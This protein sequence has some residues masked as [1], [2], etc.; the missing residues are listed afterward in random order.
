MDYT[1]ILTEIKQAIDTHDGEN[2]AQA[3]R[4]LKAAVAVMTA[5]LSDLR[6]V[7]TPKY[8]VPGGIP[9]VAPSGGQKE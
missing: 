6:G 5:V 2:I 7:L 8:V 9:F 3:I 4:E 1:S